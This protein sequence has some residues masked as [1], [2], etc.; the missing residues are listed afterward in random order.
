MR[1]NA[2]KFERRDAAEAFRLKNYATVVKLLQPISGVLNDIEL[3][4][5]DYA[6]KHNGDLTS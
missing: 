5:L 3:K 2:H 1:E 4:K 6:R